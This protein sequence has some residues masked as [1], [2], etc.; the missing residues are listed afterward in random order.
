MIRRCLCMFRKGR[1]LSLWLHFR[2]HFGVVLGAQFLTILLF[3]RPDGRNRVNKKESPFV[4]APFLELIII[5]WSYLFFFWNGR[6][7]AREL[8]SGGGKNPEGS[9]KEGKA[10][11]CRVR[12]QFFGALLQ[13]IITCTFLCCFFV[14]FF[15]C[16][17]FGAKEVP[18]KEG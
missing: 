2:L 4:F 6:K 15:R 8:V 3:G 13:N 5:F 12:G 1:S 17:I 10:L 14:L 16:S 7:L 18:L 9:P 11:K